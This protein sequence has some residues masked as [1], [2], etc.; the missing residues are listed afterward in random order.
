MNNMMQS[1]RLF[2]SRNSTRSLSLQRGRVR[3]SGFTIIELLVVVAIIALLTT[4]GLISFNQTN[5][6]AR[7]GKRKADLEQVRSALVLYRT[8]N[9]A[10]PSS[11]TWSSMAPIQTYISATSVKDPLPSP[12]AQYTYTSASPYTTFTLCATLEAT[13]PSS[14]C[15]N[16]P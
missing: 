4:I 10:Y 3:R 14:Y 1:V 8:D 2:L 11:I 13:T 12:Y 6:R 9:G 15:I 7:D 16:N 5:K